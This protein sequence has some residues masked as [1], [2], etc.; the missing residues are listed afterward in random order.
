MDHP[1]ATISPTN[2][3]SPV[4]VEI[5]VDGCLVMA[6]AARGGTDQP[7]VA[8]LDVKREGK[9]LRSHVVG[10]VG[11]GRPEEA[12]ACAKTYLARVASVTADGDLLY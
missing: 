3:G 4:M 7:W 12:M 10:E 6:T 8:T 9:G 2:N 5:N 1:R 11:F